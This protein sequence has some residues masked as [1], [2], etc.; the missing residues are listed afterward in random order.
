MGVQRIDCDVKKLAIPLL[1]GYP[2]HHRKGNEFFKAKDYDN[3]IKWYS[4][5]IAI[6]PSSHAYYSNRSASCKSR[7]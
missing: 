7:A 3:A 2:H 4:E 1:P 5:A 6:D